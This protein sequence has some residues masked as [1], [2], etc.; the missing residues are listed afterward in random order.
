MAFDKGMSEVRDVGVK[1]PLAKETSDRAYASM[2]EVHSDCTLVSLAEAN[3]D[4]VFRKPYG[5]V[6]ATGS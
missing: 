4:R 3:N 6:S 2:V 5:I 1:V